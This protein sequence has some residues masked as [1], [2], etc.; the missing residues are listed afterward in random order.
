MKMN[1]KS[2]VQKVEPLFDSS[3]DIIGK[4]L[5]GDKIDKGV[6]RIASQ[7]IS[8]Y[9][10]LRSADNSQK[11]LYYTILS[12]TAKDKADLRRMIQANVPELK[13]IEA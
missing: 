4:Y 2:D 11:K 9:S 3:L 12:D 10:R 1:G 6:L 7:A 13:Q 8:T 5:K